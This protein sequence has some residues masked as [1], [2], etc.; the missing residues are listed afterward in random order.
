MRRLRE[1]EIKRQKAKV[2][3]QK[4]FDSRSGCVRGKLRLP[5]F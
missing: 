2:K 4:C 3:S 1:L 5:H